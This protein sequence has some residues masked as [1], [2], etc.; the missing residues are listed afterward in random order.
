[1]RISFLCSVASLLLAPPLRLR[2]AKAN[3]R[4]RWPDMRCFPRNP[5][6]MRQPTPRTI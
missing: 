3:F 1:M 2:K 4:Q 6:S 5:L